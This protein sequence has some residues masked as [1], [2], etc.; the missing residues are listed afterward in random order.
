[1]PS[2]PNNTM[3]VCVVMQQLL[4]LVMETVTTLFRQRY[5]CCVNL[6]SMRIEAAAVFRILPLPQILVT[7]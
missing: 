5:Q 6:Q 4:L 3:P 7:S 1:M 2:P